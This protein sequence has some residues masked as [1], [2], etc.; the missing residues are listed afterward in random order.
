MLY[1]SKAAIVFVILYLI[2]YKLLVK[3]RIF[4]IR[5]IIL[6]GLA[7][8]CYPIIS[9]YSYYLR[10]K[11]NNFFN[12]LKESLN[13]LLSSDVSYFGVLISS[14]SNRLTAIDIFSLDLIKTTWLLDASGTIV[15]FFKGVFIAQLVDLYVSHTNFSVGRVFAIEYLGQEIDVANAFEL[16]LLGNILL[17]G[18]Q[19]ATACVVFLIVTLMFLLMRYLSNKGKWYF[20][21]MYMYYLLQ[22]IILLMTGNIQDLGFILR[23]T[24]SLYIISLIINSNFFKA[25]KYENSIH[26]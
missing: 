6:I 4:D 16:T 14:L 19:V 25:K 3:E 1:G 18:T 7:V 8:V 11:E 5:N 9:I 17:S 13:Y 10:F 20:Q 22:V 21:V 12:F 15:Y 26:K 24:F 2:G 23:L